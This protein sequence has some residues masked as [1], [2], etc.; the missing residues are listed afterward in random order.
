MVD[1][2]YCARHPLLAN[3]NGLWWPAD[4]RD[5]RPIIT[6]DC[7]PAIKAILPHI[8]GRD[9]IVQAG[10]NVGTYPLALADHFASVITCEPDPTN[11][12][13]LGRNLTARDSLNRVSATYGALGEEAGVCTPLV[14]RP[15]NCGAHRVDFD[16]GVTPVITID[17]LDLAACD[18]IWW[19][20]E[21]A[22]L[23]ALKGARQTIERFSPTIAVED[24]GLH[25]AF[26]IEDG[27]LQ[28]WLE[29]LG[30]TQTGR[31][32]Q[33]KVFRRNP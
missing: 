30:Y 27:A 2:G 8:R 11:Y 18:A 28:V 25:R 6:H 32:G 24:K 9:C 23:P 33:D 21:G 4:D 12:M 3:I 15:G 10:A 19:D 5:A 20:V 1:D 13:C 17:S 14:V 7:D 29:A 16:A 31:I 22:E 26:R